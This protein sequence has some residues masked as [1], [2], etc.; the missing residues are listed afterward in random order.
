[1]SCYFDNHFIGFVTFHARRRQTL[2]D[3]ASQSKEWTVCF[4]SHCVYIHSVKTEQ[5]LK[6]NPMRPETDLPAT[7]DTGRSEKDPTRLVGLKQTLISQTPVPSRQRHASRLLVSLNSCPAHETSGLYCS[8]WEEIQLLVVTLSEVFLNSGEPS[9][10]GDQKQQ[11]N[12]RPIYSYLIK[13]CW[14]CWF[15]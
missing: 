15:I 12:P 7:L 1:M 11:T 10:L 3:S 13:F 6:L 2:T 5:S 8:V 9:Q 4:M 14:L